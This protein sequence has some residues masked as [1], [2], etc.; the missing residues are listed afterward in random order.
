MGEPPA[1]GV[2]RAH[3][4]PRVVFLTVMPTP[5]MQDLFH[6]IVAAGQIDL[7]VLYMEMA[8]PDTYW[9][10]PQLPTY[11]RLLDGR[12]LGFGGARLH[13]N[14]GLLRELRG[15][16]PDLIVV[17]GYA[18]FTPQAALLWARARGIPCVLFGEL[19]GMRQRS[20][21]G[22]FLRWLAQRP[23]LRWADG[24]IAVGKRAARAYGELTHGQTPVWNLPYHCDLEPFLSISRPRPGRDGRIRFLYCG[25]LIERKGVDLLV[26][27]F[28]GLADRHPHI[29]LT[30]VGDGPLRAALADAVPDRLKG[31]VDLAGFRQI[32]EL[33]DCFAAADVFVLPSR[34][35]G[36][37]VVVNQALAAGMPVIVSDAVGSADDLVR[38]GENGAICRAGDEDSL[39]DALRSFVEAPERV[40]A[41]A[42]SSRR[43]AEGI[44]VE[45]GADTFHQICQAVLDRRTAIA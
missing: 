23:V 14:R 33:P 1:T 26:R 37:G 21:T 18:G 28:N 9:K 22:R 36:W 25:Q 42:A 40:G 41:Y 2:R 45:R 5:Y 13:W 44:T 20:R 15:A 16:R 31:R 27:A 7:R 24:I 43:L 11:A 4:K 35:D 32:A 29:D 17:S 10:E 30:L 38:P 12:W 6:G 8:A 3:S 39:A 19:P 34:H